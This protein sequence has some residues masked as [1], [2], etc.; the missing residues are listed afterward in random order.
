MYVPYI[1]GRVSLIG[2]THKSQNKVCAPKAQASF[3]TSRRADEHHLMT[4]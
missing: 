1:W 3:V 4:E 2:G